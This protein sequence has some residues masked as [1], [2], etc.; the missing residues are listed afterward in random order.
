MKSTPEIVLPPSLKPGILGGH[1]ITFRR[2][3]TR[4]L[5]DLSA[6]GDVTFFRMGSVPGYFVNHPDLVRDVLVV[7]A[8]KFKRDVRCSAPSAFWAR[9]CS[10]A[11]RKNTCASGV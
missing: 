3:P 7:N 11:R 1:F 2:N 8:Q 9:A 5:T 6:L 4:F 10:L